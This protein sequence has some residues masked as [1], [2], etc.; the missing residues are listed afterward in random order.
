MVSI[1]DLPADKHAYAMQ[2]ITV[3]VSDALEGSIDVE[4]A[5][6]SEACTT[7]FRQAV[8]DYDSN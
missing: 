5:L 4:S 6:K 3:M 1:A 8:L 2:L 7:K